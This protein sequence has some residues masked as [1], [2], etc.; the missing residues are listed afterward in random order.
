MKPIP[1]LL[2]AALLVLLCVRWPRL[3]PRIRGAAALAALALGV[4]GSGVIHPP[5]LQ[6][7][8]RDAGA[9][10][11]SFTYPVVGVLAFL[12]TGFGVGFIAPGELAVIIGGMTAG[13]GHTDLALLVAIVW[14]SALAGDLT[15]Y[16][17]GRLRGREL[18]RRHGAA[19]KLT[20]QRFEQVEGF[21]G[22]HGGKTLV[23]GRFIGLVRVITPFAAGASK[24]PAR[25]FVPYAVLGSGLWSA[26][27][28]ALGYVFWRS[29]DQAEAVARQGTLVLV[30][31]IVAA[32]VLFAAYRRLRKAS[33]SFRA[34]TGG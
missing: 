6:D 25:R 18:V 10:L 11:G 7:L 22:Q 3:S 31:V 20:P 27:F 34:I 9:T 1:L 21:L 16:T 19:V 12:E 24:M 33:A 14:A 17:L 32:L 8:A 26:A 29:F 4:W 5:N 2:A 30:G 23:V 13:Q 28:S 15:S